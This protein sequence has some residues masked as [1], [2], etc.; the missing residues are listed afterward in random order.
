MLW[1]ILTVHI[2]VEWP[3]KSCFG[4]LNREKRS[5]LMFHCSLSIYLIFL[6]CFLLIGDPSPAVDGDIRDHSAI[7]RSLGRNSSVTPHTTLNNYQDNFYNY[8]LT[9]AARKD[10]AL[11]TERVSLQSTLLPVSYYPWRVYTR[12]IW[13]MIKHPHK[14]HCLAC[15]ADWRSMA[16]LSLRKSKQWSSSFKSTQTSI[17]GSWEFGCLSQ[18]S[19][20]QERINKQLR[21]RKISS[22][23]TMNIGIWHVQGKVDNMYYKV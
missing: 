6:M 11:D 13:T 5:V 23:L 17:V 15:W 21:G 7:P 20:S 10:Q 16:A 12:A 4:I 3:R 14:M 8:C 19:I 18:T 2:L 22:R 1:L 9:E